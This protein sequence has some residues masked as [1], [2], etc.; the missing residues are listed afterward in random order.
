MKPKHLLILSIAA[1]LIAVVLV[2]IQ[3]RKEKGSPVVVFR[4][5]KA[6]GV[7]ETIGSGVEPV[8]LPGENLFPNLLK[9]APTG[10][11]EEFVTTTPVRE[12]IHPGEIVLFRHLE[13]TVDPGIRA[14]IPPGKKAVSIPVDE[15]TSVSYMVQP[16]DKVDVLAALPRP[17]ELTEPEVI[18]DVL[19][20]QA[21]GGI[22]L[23]TRP[24]LQGVEVLAVGRRN[25]PS[26]RVLRG[27]ATYGAV[28]LL[29]SME[30]AQK[31]VYARDVLGSPMTLVL[32]S[33]EDEERETP[34][35]PLSLDSPEFDRI[36]NQ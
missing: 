9:E 23:E 3:L 31:L 11:M 7:G 2:Q 8:T 36:G 14:A 10:D 35:R 18:T 13:T 5:T 12:P 32:R 20:G 15:V 1:G 34:T 30:E 26:D 22:A 21:S 27:E 29:V 6:V 28:T 4:A 25:R 16:G 17:V 19:A 24:L 33:P